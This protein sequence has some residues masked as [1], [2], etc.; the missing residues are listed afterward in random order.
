MPKIKLAENTVQ[1]IKDICK[2]FENK[3]SE[4]INV[5]HQVQSKLGYLPAEVQEVIAKELKTSVAKVYGV[6]TFYSFFTMIPQGENP[7]SICMGTAC[8][9]RGSEQVLNEFKRQ[10]K[11]EVGESTEDGKFSIN[12]LRCVGACGLAPVVTVGEKVYGRV[13][14]TDVKKIIAEYRNH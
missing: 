13:A 4:L 11:V 12:C 2:E 5:L 6:V 9:V 7:I 1:L 10:L 14:P 8:Y 3:E